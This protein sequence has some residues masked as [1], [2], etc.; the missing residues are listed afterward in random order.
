MDKEGAVYFLSEGYT[1]G[2]GDRLA[3]ALKR[4]P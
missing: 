2:L 4:L 3:A 1:I